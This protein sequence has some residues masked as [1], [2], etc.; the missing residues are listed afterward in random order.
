MII[1]LAKNHAALRTGD[2]AVSGD[3]QQCLKY[4]YSIDVTD[5]FTHIL[6]TIVLNWDIWLL[7]TFEI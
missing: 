1:R 3:I 7:R 6:K 5:D 2:V 4:C